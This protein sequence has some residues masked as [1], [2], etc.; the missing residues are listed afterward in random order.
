MLR[1]V[2]FMLISC[3]LLGDVM[4]FEAPSLQKCTMGVVDVGST[5]SRLHI[6]DYDCED[7]EGHTHEVWSKKITP[8]FASLEPMQ[9]VIDPY[10]KSLFNGAP[11]HMPVYFYATAGMRL[12]SHEQQQA[13]YAAAQHWFQQSHWDLIEAKTITGREEGVFAWLAVNHERNIVSG[14]VQ[15]DIGVMDMGGASVQIVASVA[16]SEGKNPEDIVHVKVHHQD[17]TLFVRSFLGLGATLVGQQFLNSPAC[18]PEGYPLPNGSVG[19][20]DAGH[21]EASISQL[22]NQVH[23]VNKIIQPV[24]AIETPKTWYVLGGLAYLLKEEPFRRDE[25][26]ATNAWL[27]E[28]ANTSVCRRSWSDLRVDYPNNER[29]SLS[30]FRASYYHALIEKGYGLSADKSIYLTSHDEETDW[31]LGVVLHRH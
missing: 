23:T 20:G 4:A 7:P 14:D 6:Y 10:L 5:G 12:L 29:L 3:G 30:C 27:L 2:I 11:E 19:H 26:G 21:C 16:S 31:T 9:A 24:L 25:L 18:F 15:E 8:G 28:Q 1:S 13:H 22:I 17:I